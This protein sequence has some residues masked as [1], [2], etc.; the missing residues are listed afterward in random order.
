MS[1]PSTRPR[2]RD[3]TAEP[4]ARD[5]RRKMPRDL[6]SPPPYAVRRF[7]VAEYE[8]IAR[9]GILDEDSNVELL[10][11]WIV[12]KM[13]KY[14]PHDSTIDLIVYLLNR[15]LPQG[16][17]CRS[18]NVVV[19]AD[20]EPEPDVAVVRG[21]PGD[22]CDRHPSGTDAGLIVEVADSTV[23]RDRRKARIYARA[24]VPDY[25]IVNL[26]SRQI[27]VYSQPT[28]AGKRAVYQSRQI[29]RGMDDMA[30][31]AIQGQDVGRLRVGDVLP[32]ERTATR[33][34]PQP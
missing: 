33:Q 30:V 12:P 5:Q 9:A 26:D 21:R 22:Y 8:A 3:K 17:Y 28:G 11:G 29:M 16:W 27:E 1:V 7:S 24:G 14:P 25:R 18:Q 31:L 19:T 23:A 13:T 34:T 32:P 2:S 6:R 20:S 15:Q 4:P 10:E